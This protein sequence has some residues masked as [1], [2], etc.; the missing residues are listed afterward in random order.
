[1]AALIC[2]YYVH[3]SMKNT[4]NLQITLKISATHKGSYF[5][6]PVHG[7]ERRYGF[8]SGAWVGKALF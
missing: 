1:M 5:W 6:S 8:C 4:N 3:T 7:I 2:T